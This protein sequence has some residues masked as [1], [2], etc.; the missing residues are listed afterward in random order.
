M[1]NRW[2]Q[3]TAGVLS[4]FALVSFLA[5]CESKKSETTSQAPS[6]QS[7]SLAERQP[8]MAAPTPGMEKGQAPEAGQSKPSQPEKPGGAG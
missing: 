5:G 1:K 3:W 8:G 6:D 7:Q 4:S 2:S